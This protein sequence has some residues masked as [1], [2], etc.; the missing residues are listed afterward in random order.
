MCPE[1][2]NPGL[3]AATVPTRAALAQVLEMPPS[4]APREEML[5][6]DAEPERPKGGAAFPRGGHVDSEIWLE[7]QTARRFAEKQASLKR[8]T[9]EITLK[10]S[11]ACDHDLPGRDRHR[12]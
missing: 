7:K 9:V 4:K 8:P 5:N 11:R 12:H 10:K 2:A 1:T 6:G 3:A